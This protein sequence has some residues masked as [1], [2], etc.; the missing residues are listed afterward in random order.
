MKGPNRLIEDDAL[1]AKLVA[2]AKQRGPRP[3]ALDELLHRLPLPPAAPVSTF[4]ALQKW[5]VIAGAGCAL[6]GVAMLE[7]RP[8]DPPS[9]ARATAP[10]AAVAPSVRD[11]VPPSN[12]PA[13]NAVPSTSVDDLP[14]APSRSISAASSG[15]QP[16]GSLRREIEL[17][18]AARQ[19]LTKGEADRCLASVR[20]YEAEFP[21]G[22]FLLEAKVM[23]IEATAMAGDGPRARSLARSFLAK[24]P[25]S[26]YEERMRSL[27]AS[28]EAQ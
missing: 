12:E 22:Q 2:D 26:P 15:A 3:E 9:A 18:G 4:A 16:R 28:L 24:N 6:A 1:L 21:N 25:R 5:I 13:E 11:V 20:A 17:A 8:S 23:R 27:L 14:A 19:A 10:S 7:L